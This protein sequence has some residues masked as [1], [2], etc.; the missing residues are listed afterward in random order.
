MMLVSPNAIGLSC[1]RALSRQFDTLT[2]ELQHLDGCFARGRLELRTGPFDRKWPE[3]LPALQRTSHLIE[4]D[5]GHLVVD[6]LVGIRRTTIGVV[7]RRKSSRHDVALPAIEEIGAGAGGDTTLEGDGADVAHFGKLQ[8]MG[9]AAALAILEHLGLEMQTC[10]FGEA[11]GLQGPELQHEPEIADR[12][13]RSPH[14]APPYPPCSLTLTLS[15]VRFTLRRMNSAGATRAMPTLAMTWPASAASG[16]LVS[17]SHLT[18]NESSPLAAAVAPPSTK[19]CMRACR[20][21]WIRRHNSGPFGSKTVQVR[22]RASAFL[23]AITR[24]RTLT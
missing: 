13:V 17:A 2:G 8:H 24:R 3:Q 20:L 1:G 7:G 21:A 12:V 22:V 9:V 10:A 6:V 4:Q 14:G 18:K 19:V 16:G 23:T 15:G 5:D 11:G